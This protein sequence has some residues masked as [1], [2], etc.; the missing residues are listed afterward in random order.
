[1]VHVGAIRVRMVGHVTWITNHTRANAHRV[2][3]GITAKVSIYL[4]PYEFVNS[5]N[6]IRYR[7]LN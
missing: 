1:M 4:L 7:K 2:T 6:Y 3:L 5:Y